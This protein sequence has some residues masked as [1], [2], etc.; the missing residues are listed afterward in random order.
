[1]WQRADTGQ[2]LGTLLLVKDSKKKHQEKAVIA[3]QER[4][5]AGNFSLFQLVWCG[6]RVCAV[7]LY[8]PPPNNEDC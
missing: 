3:Q 1:M 8:Q 5:G 4:S 2:P 6:R 7:T